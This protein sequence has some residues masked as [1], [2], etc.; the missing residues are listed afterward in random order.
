MQMRKKKSVVLCFVVV[1]V[2]LCF[3]IT[4]VAAKPKAKARKKPATPVAAPQVLSDAD[5]MKKIQNNFKGIVPE[6]TSKSPVPG[7]YEVVANKGSL[8]LYYSP[9]ANMIFFGDL[10]RSDMKSLTAERKSA[11]QQAKFKDINLDSAI[12]IGNGKHQVIEF[13]DPDCPYC[14]KAAEYFKDKDITKYVFLRPILQ[15]HPRAEEKSK[16]ILAAEDPVKAYYEVMGGKQDSIPDQ[17]V[18]ATVME[19][20]A[21]H[22]D[23]ANRLGV[24]GTPMFYIDGQYVPGAN[25]A[26]IDALLKK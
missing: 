12:K 4:A 23:E 9:E 22:A 3:A 7:V 10:I 15:L 5:I 1:V 18:S 20:L 14:R 26:A 8:V 6:S 16:Y 2:C 13:T 11:I 21:A 19:R 25:F 24:T 17:N